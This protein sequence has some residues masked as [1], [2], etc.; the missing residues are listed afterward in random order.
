MVVL[1][2][3]L[4]P[5][6][7]LECLWQVSFRY[8]LAALVTDSWPDRTLREPTFTHI[9]DESKGNIPISV[10]SIGPWFIDFFRMGLEPENSV[11]VCR[12]AWACGMLACAGGHELGGPM[13]VTVWCHFWL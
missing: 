11:G 13:W 7:L 6:R 1:G 12:C 9:L 2:S 5:A 3:G 10:S 4:H 8:I